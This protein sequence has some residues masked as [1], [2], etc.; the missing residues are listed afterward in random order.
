VFIL[1]RCRRVG[2]VVT[3][4]RARPVGVAAVAERF[5]GGVAPAETLPEGVCVWF[6]PEGARIVVGDVVL[7]A[8]GGDG[9]R[10]A[11]GRAACPGV[12]G[13]GLLTGFERRSVRGRGLVASVVE[14]VFDVAF[15]GGG[16]GDRRE[17][18]V[19][20]VDVFCEL[21]EDR[22]VVAERAGGGV[23]V[24]VVAG[25]GEGDVGALAGGVFGDDEVRGVGGDPLC[26]EGVLDV[27]QPRLSGVKLLL[28]ERGL[29]TVGEPQG[30]G[31]FVRFDAGE[32]GGSAVAQD[33]VLEVGD[34]GAQL[35]LVPGAQV[36]GAAGDGQ[37]LVPEVAV[38]AADGL[39][40]GVELVEVV[41]GGL[42]DHDGS[43]SGALIRSR[44]VECGVLRSAA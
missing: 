9:R 37:G 34:R 5:C 39:G 24:G 42:R 20:V 38:L 28:G 43:S 12:V 23:E 6:W 15:V 41:V 13:L 27:G 44:S 33:A 40:A 22:L 32:G 26:G 2:L 19:E 35:D 10:V 31:L 1:L 8:V 7:G 16:L 21:G 29:T 36:I 30:R 11:L 3:G 14:R 25:A 18:G 17:V 4:E